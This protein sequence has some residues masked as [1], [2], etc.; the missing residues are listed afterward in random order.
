MKTVV[1]ALSLGTLVACM[2]YR[3]VTSP[4][5]NWMRLGGYE[6]EGYPRTF[7]ETW[8]GKCYAVTEAWSKSAINGR[9][10]WTKR[11]SREAV[12]CP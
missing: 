2:P 9:T 3:T 12:A 1:L 8:E 6:P 5:P 7:V 10:L 11:Q 4:D